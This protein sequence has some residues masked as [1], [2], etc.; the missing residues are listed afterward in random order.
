M[1]KVQNHDFNGRVKLL[2]CIEMNISLVKLFK[3]ER[4][5]SWWIPRDSSDVN[6]SS[7][8]CRVRFYVYI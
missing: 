1:K 8:I 3:G 4:L 5:G 2:A 6:L 7:G